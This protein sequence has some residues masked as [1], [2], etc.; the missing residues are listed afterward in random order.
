MWQ[1]VAQECKDCD[2]CIRN[3][4]SQPAEPPP[5]KED[6]ASYP[7]E[8][9]SADLCHFDGDTWLVLVDWFSNFTFAKNLGKT[10]GTDKVI[11]KLRKIFFTFGLCNFLKTDAGPEWRGRFQ[12]WATQAGIV[13]SYSSAYNS[14]GNSRAEKAVQETKKLLRK[15]KDEKGDWLLAF[16]ELRNC[17]TSQGPSPAQ[18]FY[19]RQ[20]RSCVLPELFQEV[21]VEKMMLDRRQQERDKRA[22][23]VTRYPSRVFQRDEK[24]WMQSRDSH[25]WDIPGW[26]RGARPH[27]KSFIVETDSGGLYLRNRKFIK[28]REEK[29]GKEKISNEGEVEQL[30]Q[31]EKEAAAGQ[32]SGEPGRRRSYATVAR[33][34]VKPTVHK[35]VTTRSRAREDGGFQA[36]QL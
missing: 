18:L 12:E 31:E 19:S 3:Q 10:G 20:V 7:M 14:P 21:D 34:A 2:T 15:V 32:E 33:E 11:K 16:S 30:S 4:Q 23:R 13:T 24:V 5:E 9:M 26:I 25:K 28:S 17:P 1:Q 27:G 29:E 22:E 36:I 8:K 35:G 6:L